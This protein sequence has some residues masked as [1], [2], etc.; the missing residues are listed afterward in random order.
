[1]KILTTAFSL[2]LSSSA[3]AVTANSPWNEILNTSGIKV[4]SPTFQLSNGFFL[5]AEEV[6]LTGGKIFIKGKKTRKVCSLRRSR[7]DN[8]CNAYKTV[9]PVAPLTGTTSRTSCVGS[10][11]NKRCSTTIVKFNHPTSFNVDV[12]YKIR[13]ND[14]R[15][16]LFK[17][18]MTLPSCK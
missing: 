14:D 11:D 4:N 9:T 5:N 17:K 1:M 10:N 7:S 18:R 2:L 6:C 12:F 8:D 16:F 13:K 3:F 15:E